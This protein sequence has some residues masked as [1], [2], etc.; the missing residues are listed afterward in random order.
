M[1][2]HPINFLY[3]LEATGD[4]NADDIVDGAINGSRLVVSSFNQDWQDLVNNQSEIY[5][6]VVAISAL[7]GVVFVSFWSIN[8]YSRLTQEGFS[9]EVLNEMVYPLL[10]CL[11]LTVNNGQ[12]LAATSLMFRNTAINLND[13]LLSITRDGITLRDAI[14]TTNM[15]QAFTISVQTQLQECEQ[16]P[17]TGK[18]DQGN[19]INP[20][21]KCKEEKINQAEQKAQ[22]YKNKY[23]LSS[24]SNSWNPLDIAGQTINSMVQALS[25]IIFSGLQAAFQYV[26]QV[27]FLLNAYV[28]PIF[29]VLSLF[30]F[31]GKPI[32]AWVSGWLALT[33]V[34]MSHS[35]VCGIAASAIVNASN[36]NPLFL[37]LVE[38]ILSPILAVAMGA[39][40]GMAAFSCF[41]SSARLISGRIFR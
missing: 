10:V 19:P 27:A 22:E 7:C 16:K 26:V 8:W 13:K 25:W 32:Y 24:Y 28:A 11:M 40:A 20:R 6:A 41:S 2:I 17:K 29:L 18:D 23:G 31:G 30:P 21:E 34:L 35:I 14:R 37:Q 3:L 15:D 1:L 5:K 4:T 39:G 38:A 33:L 9:N 12:L 36:N